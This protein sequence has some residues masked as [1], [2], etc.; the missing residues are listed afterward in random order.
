[1]NTRPL[2]LALAALALLPA[3]APAAR[4]AEARVT[5]L[6]WLADDGSLLHPDS[7]VGELE[8]RLAAS[9]VAFLESSGGAFV[10]VLVEA[11]GGSGPQWSVQNLYLSY[12][13]TATLLAS[14]PSV[15]FDLAVPDGTH[16]DSLHLAVEVT[17]EP[18]AQ[19]P[20]AAGLRLSRVRHAEYLVGGID[21]G[22]GSSSLPLDG[23]GP[24]LGAP[25]PGQPAAPPANT[26]AGAGVA[27]VKEPP[28]HCAPGSCARSLKALF[29]DK[30]KDPNAAE[31]G[32]AKAMKT[33]PVAGTSY[34]NML[35][36]K[37]AFSTA[38]KL[39]VA[40]AFT[41]ELKKAHDAL[42][43]GGDVEVIIT[44]KGGG[45][46]AAFVKQIVLMKGGTAQITY[47]DDPNQKDNKAQNKEHVIHIA[48]N[49]AFNQGQVIAFLVETKT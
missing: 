49:G 3:T 8:L 5:Q 24:W 14:R 23:G 28:M 17:A 21:G 43:A 27:P 20:G 4:A 30:I 11:G 37:K 12:P 13:D 2:A 45:G 35:A 42:A 38:R 31:Q 46:H 44:W 29:P 26:P 33:H 10:N 18:A 22:S 34:Q 48:A 19:P 6:H 32:L 1:M 39:P 9:D 15:Q 25:V 41:N 16:L 36:G 40:S 47:V 7:R